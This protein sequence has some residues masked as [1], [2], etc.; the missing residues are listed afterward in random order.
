MNNTNYLISIDNLG[1]ASYLLEQEF[2]PGQLVGTGAFVG[3]FSTSNSADISPNILGPRCFVWFSI[4]FFNEF[5][6]A[7]YFYREM[8]ESVTPSHLHALLMMYV[9]LKGLEK[10]TRKIQELLVVTFIK[11]LPLD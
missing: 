7:P 4:A 9:K 3:A 10:L 8:E 2:N 6:Q 1:Y 11:L 5:V